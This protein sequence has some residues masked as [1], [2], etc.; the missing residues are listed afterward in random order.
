[1]FDLCRQPRLLQGLRAVYRLGWRVSRRSRA[2][3]DGRRIRSEFYRDVWQNAADQ[4]AASVRYLDDD[5]IEI[6]RGDF[7]TRVRQNETPLDDYVTLRVAGNKPLTYR[8]LDEAGLPIP[9][10]AVFSLRNMAPAIEFLDR[11]DR[12]CVV[13]PA[14]DTGGG[15]GVITGV[16]SHYR[17][18]HAAA[19]ASVV[20]GP[21]LLIEEQSPGDNYRL[22]YLD[23][24]LVDAVVRGAPSVVGDG[25]STVRELLD[26]SN[27]AR[28]AKGPSACQALLRPDLEMRYTLAAQ[29]LKLSSRPAPGMAVKLK[30]VINDNCGWENRT[31][32][33]MLSQTIIDDGARAAGALGVRLAGVDVITTDPSVPLRESRGVILEVNTSP[34]HHWHYHKCDGKFHLAALVLETVL[35]D[36][37]QRL[38]CSDA[39]L[40]S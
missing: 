18:A 32:T 5:V 27:E 24:R 22:L 26:R 11:R 16:H 29:G 13:K 38:T 34:G 2:A 40:Q 17:L 28:R 12:P 3:A 14:H 4:F 25:R 10:H 23:G 6:E 21:E 30:T 20:Y 33:D 37:H 39:I 36:Q 9:E 35:N 1:M 8:L 31:A 7:R 19:A 15:I